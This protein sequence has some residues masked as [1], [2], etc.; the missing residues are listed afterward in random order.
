L[1]QKKS[2]YIVSDVAPE[3]GEKTFELPRKGIVPLPKM[4]PKQFDQTTEFQ[5]NEAVM[6]LF[7]GTTSFYEAVVI[8]TPSSTPDA[9]YMVRRK[10]RKIIILNFV[11]V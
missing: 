5:K 8:E 2:Y 9:C 7:P 4:V 10:G 11:I 6:A 3:D 1:G